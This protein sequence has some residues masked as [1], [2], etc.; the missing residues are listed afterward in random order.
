ML[1]FLA[2]VQCAEQLLCPRAGHSCSRG[3][4]CGLW[5]SLADIPCGRDPR[6][7][8]SWPRKDMGTCEVMHLHSLLYG[9][10]WASPKPFP[11][12][13]PEHANISCS[14]TLVLWQKINTNR[15]N[16]LCSLTYYVFVWLQAYIFTSH[17]FCCFIIMMI[18]EADW[19]GLL[20]LYA[21][22]ALQII[23]WLW[24]WRGNKF[25]KNSSCGLREL[26]SQNMWFTSIPCFLLGS[27]NSTG[28]MGCCCAV[29]TVAVRGG[30]PICK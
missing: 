8:M 28:F 10:L 7:S 12:G 22:E 21:W 18:F 15:K 29:R 17:L 2:P 19:T 16:L 25:M 13:W 5:L 26:M 3:V 6:S 30:N 1:A 14:K 24:N 27:V 4:S 11:L 20:V 9:G 23:T